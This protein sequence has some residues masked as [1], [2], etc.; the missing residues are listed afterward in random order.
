MSPHP[1]IDTITTRYIKVRSLNATLRIQHAHGM[2]RGITVQ[3]EQTTAAESEKL[4]D[5]LSPGART[6]VNEVKRMETTLGEWTSVVEV[7]TKLAEGG[8][9]AS[10]EATR[11][12]TEV[13]ESIEKLLDVVGKTVEKLMA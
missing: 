2:T 5:A 8:T 9:R 10:G 3:T 1:A 11:L 12:R 6:F 4:L 13:F 7:L